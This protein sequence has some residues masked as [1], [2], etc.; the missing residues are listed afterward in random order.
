MK[1]PPRER[2]VR[3]FILFSPCSK[4]PGARSGGGEGEAVR[5]A[6]LGSGN[7]GRAARGWR[8][9]VASGRGDARASG[10]VVVVGKT[11]LPG[12]SRTREGRT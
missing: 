3:A 9:R 10:A 7:G 2:V 11:N 8:E 5:R 1:S 6:K 4:E 12:V